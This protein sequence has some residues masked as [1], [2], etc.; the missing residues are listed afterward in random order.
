MYLFSFLSINQ[1]AINLA[2]QSIGDVA[3]TSM[4][5]SMK[6]INA[7]MEI[8]RFVSDVDALFRP[9]V[10]DILNQ[11]IEAFKDKKQKKDQN[12]LYVDKTTRQIENRFTRIFLARLLGPVNEIERYDQ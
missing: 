11:N 10:S 9:Q 8:H 12:A 6:T 2:A 3:L 7:E 5:G 1:T 4:L